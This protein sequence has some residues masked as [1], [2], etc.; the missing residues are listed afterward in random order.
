MAFTIKYEFDS[1]D[2]EI[3]EEKLV[4]TF[5]LLHTMWIKACII[6]EKQNKTISVLHEEK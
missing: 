6:V 5:T 2:E 3:I 1:I 4:E